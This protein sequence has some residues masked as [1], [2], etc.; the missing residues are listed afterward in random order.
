MIFGVRS[1]DRKADDSISGI[2]NLR[3]TARSFAA[4]R[5]S[6]A[7][8]QEKGGTS[9]GEI[10]KES[11]AGKQRGK[12]ATEKDKEAEQESNHLTGLKV[13]V[14]LTYSPE[15]KTMQELVLAA[16]AGMKDEH[17]S[18]SEARDIK[19]RLRGTGT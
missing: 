16:S 1:C 2:T 5:L 15:A 14:R 19:S 11:G 4:D 12:R 13:S 18:Q 10:K 9:K 17:S 7:K 3:W 8:K 6:L